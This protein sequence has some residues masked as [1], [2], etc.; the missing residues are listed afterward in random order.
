MRFHEILHAM[1]KDRWGIFLDLLLSSAL[2]DLIG[3]S[4]L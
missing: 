2:W 4:D 1:L 3:G